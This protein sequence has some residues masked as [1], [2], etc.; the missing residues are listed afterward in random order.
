MRSSVTGAQSL[1]AI[2][3]LFCAD[4]E[5]VRRLLCLQRAAAIGLDRTTIAVTGVDDLLLSL[6]LDQAARRTWALSQADLRQDARE[7]YRRRKVTLR[8]ALGHPSFIEAQ[9]GGEAILAS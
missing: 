2:E 6:G 4:S 8:K 9:L 1:A 5:A 3:S 7:N